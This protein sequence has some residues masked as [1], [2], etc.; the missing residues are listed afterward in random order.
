[1]KKLILNS[2]IYEYLAENVRMGT[3]KRNIQDK[4]RRK[5]YYHAIKILI[6]RE[7]K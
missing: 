7:N 4:Y 1:M 5:I 6:L 2:T 3:D